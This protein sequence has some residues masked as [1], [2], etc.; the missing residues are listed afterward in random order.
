MFRITLK[1]M[2]ARKTRLLLTS[3][4]VMLGTAFLTGTAVFTDTIKSTFDNLFADVFDSVDAYTRSTNVIE[5]DFGSEERGKV[6]R[7]LVDTIT[8]VPGVKDS[9]AFIQQFAVIIGK[10]GEPLGNDGNGPPSFGGTANHGDLGFWTFNEG[11]VPTAPGEVA[12]DEASFEKEEF[13]L[14]DKVTISAVGGTRQFTIVGVA[15]FGDVRSPGGS[16]FA[17]FED[18]TASQFLNGKPDSYDAI[19][20]EGDGSVGEAEL[21]ERIS[22]AI[23]ADSATDPA[24]E[25]A[26][27]TITG[28]QITEETQSDIRKG[29]S[30]IS[31]FL[32]AF[33]FIALF[34]ATFV[35]YNLFS[36]TVAQRRRENALLRAVG[37]SRRQVTSA[38]LM[39][40]ITIGL[41]GSIIGLFAGVGLS[42]LLKSAFTAFGIDI[43]SNGVTLRSSTIITTLIVGV[44]V[45][46]MSAVLPAFRSS[47]VPPVAAMRA[48]AIEATGW[49]KKRLASGGAVL[50]I[51][52][53]AI[54]GAL[55]G[56]KATLLAPGALGLFIGL[57]I[58]GPLVAGPLAGLMRAPLKAAKG[59][60]G[61]MA[62]DNAARNP[63]RTART[64]AALL[65]GAALVTS[66]TVLASSVKASVR[67]IFGDQFRGDLTVTT[68]SFGFGGL[69][70]EL[71]PALDALPEIETA[72]GIGISSAL[73]PGK[74]KGT[75]VTT[76]D[77]AT[78]TKLF[79]LQ[80]SAGRI[81]SLDAGSIAISRDKADDKSLAL[82]STVEFDLLGGR[83]QSLKVV[84]IYDEDTLAGPFTVSKAVFA[85]AD[86][87]VFDFSVFMTKS[88]GTTDEAAKA[89][90][91]VV[92]RELA[93]AGQVKLRQEY[94]DEQAAQVDPLLNLIYGLLALS[95]IIAAIGIIIT[96]L[97]SVYERRRELGLVR[98]IGMTRSQVRSSIR[99]E[100]VI[101]T[102]LGA[103]QGAIVGLLLGFAVVYSLRDE[104]LNVFE[105]PLV[106][107]GV[108]FVIAII[109]GVLAAII[110]A[111]RAT[112]L[113]I[114]DAIATT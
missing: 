73:L 100:A 34:V 98:A 80:V 91:T 53:A 97:L 14:G 86:D 44:G 17:L 25:P 38:L 105:V 54:L 69:P 103:V 56:K 66:V 41:I 42:M 111:R 2:A 33:A 106:R 37:A 21:V 113:N 8:T 90:V 49:S 1:G 32:T 45:T 108:I 29:L 78:V 87:N 50:A 43:P 30:F 109:L 74:T 114:L 88:A 70:I 79:D 7:S 93:P 58:L 27:E 67:D 64:A 16:S 92:S 104:G 84:A 36:I 3:L 22:S 51:G 99:W 15:K 61:Q 65:V 12:L 10:D 59:I 11:R 107:I 47:K 60:T 94:I 24:A 89:A 72:T 52:V 23:T 48:E 55:F 81:E 4:A 62:A 9:Q 26:V 101:V 31:V 39:E 6:S 85:G 77:P 57:F 63:K 13:A 5:Q 40:A 20:T 46:V 102:L 96:L 35:I 71:A 112:K 95:V 18:Q 68:N 82:G 76:V 110:P 19:I 28:A 75:F 83:P